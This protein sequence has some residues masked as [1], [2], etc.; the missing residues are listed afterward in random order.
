MRSILAFALL[1]AA[2]SP[3]TAPDDIAAHAERMLD[4]PRA[5]GGVRA[6]FTDVLR[7]YALDELDKDPFVFPHMSPEVGPAARE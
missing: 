4:D 1:V 6:L 3:A 5:R 2:C 7:L